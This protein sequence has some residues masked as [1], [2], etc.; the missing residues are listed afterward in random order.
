MGGGGEVW[1][2]DSGC[3]TEKLTR[4]PLTR[5]PSLCPSLPPHLLLA[6]NWQ[7][8]FFS[9]PLY[10]LLRRLFPLP[11]PVPLKRTLRF[12]SS[13]P[14]PSPTPG[15]E[16]KWLS[17]ISVM[18]LPKCNSRRYRPGHRGRQV[19]RLCSAGKKSSR[20]GGRLEKVSDYWCSSV[21]IS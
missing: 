9:P 11:S 5:A 13:P 1:W 6:V 16:N 14:P 12:P 17:L 15:D 7:S 18:F 4:A 19:R 2:E 10:T 3:V 8:I 20:S 21:C